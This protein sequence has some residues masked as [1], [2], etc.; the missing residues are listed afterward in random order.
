MKFN[1]GDCVYVSRVNANFVR[2]KLY[3]EGEIIW[4]EIH[5][6]YVDFGN[7]ASQISNKNLKL[8]D[9][10]RRKINMNTSKVIVTTEYTHPVVYEDYESA[11]KYIEDELKI[12]H[13]AVYEIWKLDQIAKIPS[14]VKFTRVNN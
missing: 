10:V 9:N 2:T 14:Q 12:N 4:S 11:K 3:D 6:S 8:T 1:P 7:Y 5:M 13:S